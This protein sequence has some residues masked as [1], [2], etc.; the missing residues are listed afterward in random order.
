MPVPEPKPDSGDESLLPRPYATGPLFLELVSVEELQQKISSIFGRLALSV[1]LEGGTFLVQSSDSGPSFVEIDI[2][3]EKIR[4]TPQ[5]GDDREEAALLRMK[6]NDTIASGDATI[7]AL[8]ALRGYIHIESR[9][10]SK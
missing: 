1:V 10:R 8:E 3:G 2:R 4:L 6:A 5:V 9:Y 7:I